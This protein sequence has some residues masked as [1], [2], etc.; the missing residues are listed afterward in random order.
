[1]KVTYVNQKEFTFDTFHQ[2]PGSHCVELIIEQVVAVHGYR[3]EQALR[4]AV[5]TEVQAEVRLSEGQTCSYR[6]FMSTVR[7]RQILACHMAML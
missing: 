3:G 5:Q 4:P 1:M 7:G 2:T 6:Q